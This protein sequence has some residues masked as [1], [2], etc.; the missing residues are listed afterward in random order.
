MQQACGRPRHVDLEQLAWVGRV[1]RLHRVLAQGPQRRRGVGR[2]ATDAV[3]A[4]DRLEHGQLR[5]ERH[6]LDARDLVAVP[7][8]GRQ[9]RHPLPPLGRLNVRLVVVPLHFSELTLVYPP[10]RPLLPALDHR[11][12]LVVCAVQ[13]RPTLERVH[14]FVLVQGP[15]PEGLPRHAVIP[16]RDAVVR[17][18][19]LTDPGVGGKGGRYQ[20][21]WHRPHNTRLPRANQTWMG[22]FCTKAH[23]R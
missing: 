23:E 21:A 6:G 17:L 11:R 9:R 22:S 8:Q 13:D 18:E 15:L 1:R 7:R 10:L 2:H 19:L 3:V 16:V 4:V 12:L 14:Q 20:H 5:V